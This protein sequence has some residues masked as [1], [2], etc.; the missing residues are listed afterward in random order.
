MIIRIIKLLL[1][2]FLFSSYSFAKTTLHEVLYKAAIPYMVAV[3]SPNGESDLPP[4]IYVGDAQQGGWKLAIS[5]E[6]AMNYKTTQALHM[7]SFASE[8]ERF[9]AL[10]IIN[11]YLSYFNIESSEINKNYVSIGTES[12]P[13]YD[14]V[15]NAYRQLPKIESVYDISIHRVADSREGI[16]LV[17]VSQKLKDS[18]NSGITYA[19]YI[20]FSSLANTSK[21]ACSPVVL[22]YTFYPVDEL[23]KFVHTFKEN[24]LLLKS[25]YITRVYLEPHDEEPSF[26]TAWKQNLRKMIEEGRYYDAVSSIPVP[27]FD[28]VQFKTVMSSLP[29][30]VS[31]VGIFNFVQ[32]YDP[33]FKKSTLKIYQEAKV[34][35]TKRL[36]PDFEIPG[37]ILTAFRNDIPF[38]LIQDTGSFIDF[39]NHVFVTDSKKELFFFVDSVPYLLLNNEVATPLRLES[40]PLMTSRIVKFSVAQVMRSPIMGK[41]FNE[42]FLISCKG[43]K[44]GEEATIL[45]KFKYSSSS[46][47]VKLVDSFKINDTFYGSTEL[48]ARIKDGLFDHTTEC[49]ETIV[50]YRAK[51]NVYSPHIDLLNSTSEVRK[52]DYVEPVYLDEYGTKKEFQ[53]KVFGSMEKPASASGIYYRGTNHIS[54]KYVSSGKLLLPKDPKVPYWSTATFNSRKGKYALYL[55]NVDPQYGTGDGTFASYVLI[56]PLDLRGSEE[57]LTVIDLGGENC[58]ISNLDYVMI[59][60]SDSFDSFFI[61]RSVS[62]G[63]AGKEKHFI[64]VKRIDASDMLDGRLLDRVMF[65]AQEGPFKV[66]SNERYSADEVIDRIVIG[67]G[68][69]LYWVVSDKLSKTDPYFTLQEL[70]LDRQIRPA[71]STEK[72]TFA[73]YRDYM[74]NGSSSTFSSGYDKGPAYLWKVRR[75]VDEDGVSKLFQDYGIDRLPSKSF[76]IFPDYLFFLDGVAHEREN[77]KYIVVVPDELKDYVR[78]LTYSRLFDGGNEKGWSLQN[79]GVS[80]YIDKGI[81]KNEAQKYMNYLSSISKHGSALHKSVLLVDLATINDYSRLKAP[82]ALKVK[83]EDVDPG[84]DDDI[85]SLVSPSY[86]ETYVDPHSLFYVLTEGSEISF[87]EFMKSTE[88]RSNYSSVIVASQSEFDLLREDLGFAE[89]YAGQPEARYDI[90]SMFEIHELQPPSEEAK[91]NIFKE[92]LN[93]PD[94]R[95]VGY[96][97]NVEAINSEVGDDQEKAEEVFINYLISRMNAESEKSEEDKFRVLTKVF[98]LLKSTLLNDMHCIRNKVININV[99]EQVLGEVFDLPINLEYLPDDDP[100]KILSRA[101]IATLFQEQGGYNGFT[102]TDIIDTILSQTNQEPTKPIPASII[103]FGESGTGKTEFFL[104]LTRVLGLKIYDPKA[105]EE[106]NKDAQAFILKCSK[107]TTRASSKNNSLGNAEFMELSVAQEHLKKFLGSPLGKR[108]FILFD[109]LHAAEASARNALISQIRTMLDSKTTDIHEKGKGGSLAEYRTINN[110]NITIFVTLNPASDMDERLSKKGGSRKDI[111][112]YDKVVASLADK[113]DGSVE[114][115][116]LRRFGLVTEMRSFPDEAKRASVADKLRS[117]ILSNFTRGSLLIPTD[118]FISAIIGRFPN[119]DARALLS[120]VNN[121]VS[122]KMSKIRQQGNQSGKSAIYILDVDSSVVSDGFQNKENLTTEAALIK[123]IETNTTLYSTQSL[124]GQLYFTK[125]MIDNFRNNVFDSLIYALNS[126]GL[127]PVIVRLAY[128]AIQKHLEANP[129]LPLKQVNIDSS[130]YVGNDG[131]ERIKFLKQIDKSSFNS[132]YEQRVEF[133]APVSDIMSVY[134]GESEYKIPTL[135][136]NYM[137]KVRDFLKGFLG[138]NLGVDN[139]NFAVG[140]MSLSDWID[141]IELKKNHRY[142]ASFDKTFY[143]LFKSYFLDVDKVS[144]SSGSVQIESLSY[145]TRIRFFLAVIDRAIMSLNWGKVF[146]FMNTNLTG[147]LKQGEV[148][149]KIG[150]QEFLLKRPVSMVRTPVSDNIEVSLTQKIRQSGMRENEIARQQEIFMDNCRK[151]FFEE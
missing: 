14:P 118:S 36:S 45:Y 52:Y 64:E 33:I 60:V 92:I 19:F 28:L 109:D 46:P 125:V 130:C 47:E 80:F 98:S 54:Y 29:D 4:G 121:G 134:E 135:N 128:L 102:Q 62:R 30:V 143:S 55:L 69:I 132:K 22:E 72:L 113:V 42:M 35:Y 81:E 68:G 17:I 77:K 12:V 23:R 116:F 59:L 88:R 103:L 145:Y 112:L 10:A 151:L 63:V 20:D 32:D 141:K 99:A 148:T 129:S 120:G 18:F 124:E 75:P 117:V 126:S 147:I 37:N 65:K 7:M 21:L 140:D 95:K 53:Y 106:Y 131:G 149:S 115:S 138:E 86:I 83:F 97:Y 76:N 38:V 150:V 133:Q 139:P 40:F 122:K 144:L 79:E 57:N 123:F 16:Q 56:D 105:G 78:Y 61:L 2:S 137:I 101:D 26:A 82:D 85:G 119:A 96:R 67:K 15:L 39:Y 50:A 107:I 48:K 1:I 66:L 73:A 3:E 44:P 13:I 93:S 90:L 43:E 34:S 108:G 146:M 100:L 94:V 51:Q 74:Q 5:G 24:Q 27:L 89:G 31:K 25:T 11:G 41:D 58:G 104:A 71:D 8:T 110:R 49:S 91:F 111:T 87:Q 84:V 114:S 6:V 70:G 136:Y 127:A 142:E 9:E